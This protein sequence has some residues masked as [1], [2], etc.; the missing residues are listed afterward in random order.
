MPAD[1]PGKSLP[2]TCPKPRL[3]SVCHIC[4]GGSDNATFAAPTL[5][6]L[7]RSVA[8]LIWP[9]SCSSSNTL[10][11]TFKNPGDVSTTL[12]AR[13]CPDASADA[14]MNGLMLEPGSKMSVAARFR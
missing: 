14:M 3:V 2:V 5:L 4:S 10:S 11:P 9:R 6:D 7:A 8:K 1:S 12:S 13:Y